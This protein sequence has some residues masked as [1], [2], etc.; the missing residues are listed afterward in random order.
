MDTPSAAS[1]KLG[2]VGFPGEINFGYHMYEAWGEVDIN[3]AKTNSLLNYYIDTSGGE[4]FN[5]ME[6]INLTKSVATL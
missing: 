5:A 6:N 3:L 2:V 4:Q 1:C